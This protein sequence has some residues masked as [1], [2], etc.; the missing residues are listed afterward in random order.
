MY[1]TEYSTYGC[2]Y[3][4]LGVLPKELILPRMGFRKINFQRLSRPDSFTGQC[5]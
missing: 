3:I 1:S 5:Y 4:N 2:I